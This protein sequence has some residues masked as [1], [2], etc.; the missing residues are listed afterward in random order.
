MPPSL[1][2]NQTRDASLKWTSSSGK[3]PRCIERLVGADPRQH[4]G[5]WREL[6]AHQGDLLREALV[7]D[8]EDR[9]APSGHRSH[10][11]QVGRA[12]ST[13]PS[14]LRSQPGRKSHPSLR[15][16]PRL[17]ARRCWASLLHQRRPRPAPPRPPHQGRGRARRPP[18]LG[19]SLATTTSPADV[20]PRGA[21][22]HRRS[23]RA[24]RRRE[25]PQGR[26]ASSSS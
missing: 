26:G 18:V 22:W 24:R 2:A 23:P 1:P 14:A 20:H 17:L 9:V 25:A 4:F 10:D 21:R 6:A 15:R 12:V 13:R 3:V 16:A 8:F 11:G 19:P 7:G 5:A